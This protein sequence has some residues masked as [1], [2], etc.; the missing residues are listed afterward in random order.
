[1]NKTEKKLYRSR[2]N[3][4]LPSIRS[5]DVLKQINYN[6]KTTEKRTCN[7]FLSLLS[8]LPNRHYIVLMCIAHERHHNHEHV[9]KPSTIPS[10]FVFFCLSPFFSTN[11]SP[12]NVWIIMFVE[13]NMCAGMK[14]VKSN[15]DAVKDANYYLLAGLSA[16]VIIVYEQT[17]GD[18]SHS[19]QIGQRWILPV[20]SFNSLSLPLSF[21]LRFSLA[22]C[23]CMFRARFCFCSQILFVHRFL[24][25]KPWNAK[26]TSIHIK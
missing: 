11:F 23:V 20:F 9:F 4:Q 18:T 19:F 5:P 7:F 22:M 10:T 14:C 13:M 1:M 24:V 3:E 15:H 8:S 26:A 16:N 2:R 17:D 25:Y 6:C 21:T 12:D